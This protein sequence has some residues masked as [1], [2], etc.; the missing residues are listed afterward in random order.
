LTLYAPTAVFAWYGLCSH[1]DVAEQNFHNSDF[2]AKRFIIDGEIVIPRNGRVVS[3]F[4]PAESSGG[5]SNRKALKTKGRE[6]RHEAPAPETRQ[7]AHRRPSGK[8]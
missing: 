2:E 3:P 4:A 6:T 7:S 8:S 5:E 1:S